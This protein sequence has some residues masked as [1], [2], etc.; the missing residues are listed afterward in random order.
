MTTGIDRGR[1][2][3]LTGATGFLGSHIADALLARGYRVR[4]SVRATSSLRWIEG[5]DIETVE[6]DLTDA[7]TCTRFLAGTNGLIH[8]AGVVQAANEEGYQRG[9]TETTRALASAAARAWTSGDEAF[10]LVSS[11]AAHGPAGLDAPAVETM[12]YRTNTAADA[13]SFYR[14]GV[15]LR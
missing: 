14:V 10:V 5:K 1:L 7:D 11:L 6:V 2:I 15:D 9:N 12:I 13:K 3:A 8:N 4:A